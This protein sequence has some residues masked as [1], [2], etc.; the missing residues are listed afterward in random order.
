MKNINDVP[1]TEALRIRFSFFFKFHSNNIFY[2]II[3]VLNIIVF[4]CLFI[5][6]SI[7][8]FLVLTV[9]QL[10]GTLGE[11]LTSCCGLFIIWS[12]IGFLLGIV[13]YIL[14]K[15]FMLLFYLCTLPDLL[16]KTN[17]NND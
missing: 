15:I 7:A 3:K 16:F 17:L 2:K 11:S 4:C 10:I 6:T 8:E 12:P 5:V 14:S 1:L 9:V 13:Y